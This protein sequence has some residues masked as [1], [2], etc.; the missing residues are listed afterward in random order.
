MTMGSLA[1]SFLVLAVA[2]TAAPGQS[3]VRASQ[4]PNVRI[5]SPGEGALLIGPTRLRAEVEPPALAA[6][7]VFSVDGR[8]VCST[9]EPPFECEWDAGTTITQ[10]QV[11][12]VVNLAAGGR[13]VR[14]TR[15]T[16]AGFAE[17]VDVDMVQVTVTVTDDRGR[18]VK[19][20][21]RSAFHVSQDG[22]PQALSHFY[23]QD[24]P[25]DL[26]VAVDISG[27]MEPAMPRLR[28]AVAAFLSAVPSSHHVTLLS[29]NSD[30]FT[31][32]RHTADPVERMRAVERL[33]P[34]GSTALYDVVVQ[35]VEMLGLQA[36]RKALVVF[37]DGEDQGSR[38]TADEVEQWLQASD[39]TLY[40]IGQGRGVTNDP[41]KKVMAQLSRP[42][43]G[44]AISTE[45]IDTLHEAFSELL[46]ELSGQYVLGYQPSSAARDSSWHP[47]KV[48]VDGHARVRARLGY[49][50]VRN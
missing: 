32:T 41:L 33:S 34:W 25:M 20:L 12:L 7:V 49:R 6:S 40:M 28:T 47:I 38:V 24:A 3:L 10:H 4:A 26:V 44:R 16:G 13:I 8:D 37:T 9:I 21:P 22:R 43:G 14:T 50:V 42:T 23:S 19:G 1:V 29:F 46:D 30:V 36:G 31:I 17:T 27:S 39:V 35:G 18:C 15:T 5:V 2:T 11:R 48:D 45:S